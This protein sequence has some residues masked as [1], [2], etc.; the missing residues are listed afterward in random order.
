MFRKCCPQMIRATRPVFAK[1]LTNAF[2]Y[3]E[4]VPADVQTSAS[5]EAPA[6]LKLTMTRQDEFIF[7]EKVVKSVAL[8]T[9]NGKMGILPGHEYAVEKLEPG[10]IEIE[11]A[12]GKSVFYATSG[13][14]AHVNTDGSLDINTAECIPSALM[15]IPALEKELAANQEL[16]KNGDDDGK[17]RGAIGVEVI[18][19]VLEALKAM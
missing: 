3:I 9:A 18:E 13:G 4:Y 8:M 16:V 11:L 2:E 19:P 15:D 14:F 17:V 1:T 5:V 7:A 10:M 12:D 6:E